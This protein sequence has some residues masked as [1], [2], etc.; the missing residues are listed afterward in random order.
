MGEFPDSVP[1]FPRYRMFIMLRA[2]L[3]RTRRFRPARIARS[4]RC[5]LLAALIGGS[6][7][8]GPSA[9]V[10]H[11]APSVTFAVNSQLDLPDANDGG[12]SSAGLSD[13]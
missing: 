4:A 9:R 5:A 1:E 6:L 10:V 8:G 11:A 3:A 2:R 13:T 12:T 7:V